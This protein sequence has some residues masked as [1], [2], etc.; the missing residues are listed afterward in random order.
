MLTA[1]AIHDRYFLSV[2]AFSLIMHHFLT[3]YFSYNFSFC[4]YVASTTIAFIEA[5]GRDISH[6]ISSSYT[7]I[8]RTLLLLVIFI[9]MSRHAAPPRQLRWCGHA[10]RYLSWPKVR[11]LPLASNRVSFAIEAALDRKDFRLACFFVITRVS[12][13]D[14][15]LA[16]ESK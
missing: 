8:A 6:E 15:I 9:G 14:A 1:A 7:S 16:D 2:A 10:S 13:K 3:I 5:R 11:I 12:N 4:R